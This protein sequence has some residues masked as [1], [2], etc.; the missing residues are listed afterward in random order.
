M[1]RKVLDAAYLGAGIL[2]GV[3]LVAILV[4]MMVMSLGRPL[5]INI[6]SGDDFA[7]WSMA[8]MSFLGLA[9]TFKSGDMIRVG[10]LVDSLSGRSKQMVEII[11]LV[12]A[13]GFVGFFAWH[14]VVFTQ[15]SWILN[16]RAT[17]VV[18][19]PLWIPQLAYCGG[20]VLLTI[21]LVDELIHVLSGHPPRYEKPKPKT[22]EE[23]I[24]Q[25]IQSAV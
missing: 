16:D 11:C 25:A 18:P 6:P 1:L 22:A 8:A 12:L 3:F 9:Y 24:E 19:V 17:G 2:A 4:L 14:A 5:G 10:L 23:V 21:A 13:V 20:L 15:F 7:A